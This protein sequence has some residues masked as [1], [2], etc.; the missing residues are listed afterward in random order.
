MSRGAN[1]IVTDLVR[2]AASFIS[3]TSNSHSTE[4]PS[5]WAEIAAIACNGERELITPTNLPSLRSCAAASASRCRSSRRTFPI[6]RRSRRRPKRTAGTRSRQGAT[7]SSATARSGWSRWRAAP[8]SSTWT[9]PLADPSRG[10]TSPPWTRGSRRR[11]PAASSRATRSWTSKPSFTTA[12]ITTWTPASR[13]SRWRVP[14]RFG[15]R[16]RRRKYRGSARD[17]PGACRRRVGRD[18]RVEVIA[19]PPGVELLAEFSETDRSR[20]ALAA[21]LLAAWPLYRF[22]ERPSQRWSARLSYR[23]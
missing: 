16:P 18:V 5:E 15:R 8:T 6:A 3:A 19:F 22:I 2:D 4:S 1:A 11:P 10:S 20:L 14:S 7:G 12:A 23:A 21:C 13:P 17:R 9:T